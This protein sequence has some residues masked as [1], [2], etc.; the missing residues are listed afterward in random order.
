MLWGWKAKSILPPSQDI[1]LLFHPLIDRY[2][3]PVS[4]FSRADEKTLKDLIIIIMNGSK[5]LPPP[6]TS[7]RVIIF[8]LI[9]CRIGM[10]VDT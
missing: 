9:P 2:K 6:E 3:D 7:H 1:T 5:K 4:V 8:P 10:V